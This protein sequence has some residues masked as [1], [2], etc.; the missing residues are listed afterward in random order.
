MP[1]HDMAAL[2]VIDVAEK[3]DAPNGI[4]A[5]IA[6]ARKAIGIS[7]ETLGRR[8]GLGRDQIS[9]IESGRRKVSA[10]ELPRFA[11]AL[12]TSLAALTGA[13]ERRNLRIAAR[14]SATTTVASVARGRDRA[15]RLLEADDLLSQVG[16]LPAA[17]D[18]EQGAATLVEVRKG[19]AGTRPDADAQ[20]IGR[21]TAD[22]VRSGLGLGTA[23]IRDLPALIEKHFAVDVAVSP[24]G[25]DIDGFCVHGDHA[26]L[27][28]AS[29]DFTNGH[30]RF[31]LAHEL[32]HYLFGD[33]RELI[34]ETPVDLF[35]DDPSERRASAFAGHLLMSE[36]EIR[37]TLL[38]LGEPVGSPI[39]ERAL[40]AMMQH[41][42]V[43]LAALAVQF[44]ILGF[45]PAAESAR[46]RAETSPEDLVARH[47]DVTSTESSESKSHVE[48]VPERLIR[49][50]LEAARSRR[51]GL[52]I[53]ATVLGRPDDE[54]LWNEVMGGLDVVE[55]DEI[56]L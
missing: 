30:L 43:S 4:G 12:G 2:G 31:T 13:P 51:L 16:V 49:Y 54:T 18:S 9:K 1:N 25:S 27:I 23:P 20:T 35:K 44:D 45:I 5:R 10:S 15:R 56:E 40:V 21:R 7:G 53:V 48:R 17:R 34:E 3:N 41:F 42:G 28:L 52:S 37:A 33:P 19:L 38:W 26:S 36:S 32:A 14:L 6:E 22:I 46:L 11:M 47:G 50:A 29:S 55:D 8:V 24:M 39:S